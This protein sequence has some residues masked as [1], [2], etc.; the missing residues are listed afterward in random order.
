MRVGTRTFQSLQLAIKIKGESAPKNHSGKWLTTKQT[1][2]YL[3]C[4]SVYLERDR[5]TR[6]HG[7]LFS[8]MGWHIKYAAADLDALLERNKE[9]PC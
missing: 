4:S 7:I 3:G 5:V 9:K 6:L 8:K 1:A 2:K